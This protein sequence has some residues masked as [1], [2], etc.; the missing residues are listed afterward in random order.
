VRDRLWR[1]YGQPIEKCRY[2]HSHKCRL[3]PCQGLS[4]NNSY[5]TNVTGTNGTRYFSDR[6]RETRKRRYDT[7]NISV[8]DVMIKNVLIYIPRSS[9]LMKNQ[10]ASDQSP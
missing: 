6:F 5:L 7:D 1:Y 4:E 10:V 3:S 2:H 9:S 8:S